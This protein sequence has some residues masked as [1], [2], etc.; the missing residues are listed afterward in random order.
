MLDFLRRRTKSEHEHIAALLSAYVDGELTAQG[1]QRV[2]AHLAHC[3]ACAED[4]RTLRYTK[5]LLAEVPMPRLPRSFVVRRADLEVR[6]ATA[7]RRAFGLRSGLAYAYLRG[8][9]AVVAVAFALLLAG[10]LIAQLGFGSLGT[11]QPVMVPVKGAD[12]FERE[13]AVEVTKVVEKSLGLEEAGGVEGTPPPAVE[14]EVEMVVAPAATPSPAARGV[15]PTA[16]LPAPEKAQEGVQPLAVP[17]EAP[18]QH[19]ADENLM[20]TEIAAAEEA[21]GAGETSTPAPMP[22]VTPPSPTPSLTATPSAAIPAGAP[23]ETDASLRSRGEGYR[24]PSVIRMAEIGLGGLALILLVVTL[25]VRRRQ[26]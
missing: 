25:I 20:P 14:K 8:A 11:R 18:T 9:T 21:Y 10:D 19:T 3:E 23:E 6:P 22:A 7:R 13:A 4:L 24:W 1:Q 26:S 5:A 15:S 17:E 12:V 16:S 2:K